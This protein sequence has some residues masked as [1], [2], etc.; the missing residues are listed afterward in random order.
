M[1][2]AMIGNARLMHFFSANGEVGSRVDLKRSA[3]PG[4]ES[5]DKQA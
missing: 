2:A 3:I 1:T 5:N 4:F